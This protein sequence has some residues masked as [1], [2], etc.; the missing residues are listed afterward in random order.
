MKDYKLLCSVKKY[1]LEKSG[2]LKGCVSTIGITFRQVYN[3]GV[4]KRNEKSFHGL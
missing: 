1:S 2:R 4:E 3:N